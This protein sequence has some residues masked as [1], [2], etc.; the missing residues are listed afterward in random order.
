MSSHPNIDAFA[1]GPLDDDDLM[2][3]QLVRDM[4]ESVDPVPVELTDR[5]QYAMTVA[6]LHAEVASIVEP[7]LTAGEVRATDYDRASSITFV[8]GGLTVMVSVE[9]TGTDTTMIRGWLTTPGAEVELRERSRTRAIIAD[10]EGRF[11]VEGVSRGLVHLVI[12]PDGGAKP[13]ITPTFEV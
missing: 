1:D 4:L 5:A 3:I 10:N 7:E 13:V 11:L 9:Q 6:L 12:R 2:V 8:S